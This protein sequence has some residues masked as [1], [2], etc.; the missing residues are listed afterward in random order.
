MNNNIEIRKNEKKTLNTIIGIIVISLFLIGINKLFYSNEVM[1]SLIGYKKTW[2]MQH[3][4][5]NF[6]YATVVAL[7]YSIIMFNKKDFEKKEIWKSIICIIFLI[8]VPALLSYF[9]LYH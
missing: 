9:V 3:L 7:I 6:V 8:C 2:Q 1:I 4:K 5:M